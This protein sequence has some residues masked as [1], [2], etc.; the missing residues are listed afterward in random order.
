MKGAHY[1]LRATHFSWLK[2]LY[3]LQLT[4]PVPVPACVQSV[5]SIA[6]SGNW[7]GKPQ[8]PNCCILKSTEYRQ[9]LSFAVLHTCSNIPSGMVSHHS[10]LRSLDLCSVLSEALLSTPSCLWGSSMAFVAAPFSR[11]V[12]HYSVGFAVWRLP[13]RRS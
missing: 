10:A 6:L 11:E 7:P 9:V 8:P 12:V 1:F 13:P 4:R 5:H 3:A 2:P